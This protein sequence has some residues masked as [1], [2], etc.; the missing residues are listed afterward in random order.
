MMM[1]MMMRAF[2]LPDTQTATLSI[3]KYQ[4]NLRGIIV[5]GGTGDKARIAQVA[6]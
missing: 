2:G 6:T 4:S 3:F 1:M 5:Q